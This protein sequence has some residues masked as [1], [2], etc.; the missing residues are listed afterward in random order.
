MTTE[1]IKAEQQYKHEQAHKGISTLL[2]LNAILVGSLGAGYI[3]F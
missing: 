1:Q 3:L 2:L